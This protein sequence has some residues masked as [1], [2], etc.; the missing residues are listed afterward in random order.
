MR[1]RSIVPTPS[2]AMKLAS[3]AVMSIAVGLVF[4]LTLNVLDQSGIARLIDDSAD[5]GTTVLLFVGTI[6]TTFGMVRP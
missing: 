2:V 6:V 5:Q 1:R 4:D 3:N